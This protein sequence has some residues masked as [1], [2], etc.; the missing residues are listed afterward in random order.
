MSTS[1]NK[2]KILFYEDKI[3][4]NYQKEPPKIIKINWLN[5]KANDKLIALKAQISSNKSYRNTS[6]KKNFR[7]FL[8]SS[9]HSVEIRWKGQYLLSIFRAELITEICE[10]ISKNKQFYIELY[11]LKNFLKLD[12][13]F[14]K[15]YLNT[16]KSFLFYILSIFKRIYL[17]NRIIFLNQ[18]KTYKN[19]YFINKFPDSNTLSITCFKRDWGEIYEIQKITNKSSKFIAIERSRP[20]GEKY[21]ILKHNYFLST[22]EI[23]KSLSFLSI[24]LIKK[25]FKNKKRLENILKI[26]SAILNLPF[27]IK[28]RHIAK[29]LY[30]IN[31]FKTIISFSTWELNWAFFLEAKEKNIKTNIL[32]GPIKDP[33]LHLYRRPGDQIFT[34][35]P[36]IFKKKLT[37]RGRNIGGLLPSYAKKINKSLKNDNKK[38]IAWLE[39]AVFPG[40]NND[41]EIYEGLKYALKIAELSGKPLFVRFKPNIENN[42]QRKKFNSLISEFDVTIVVH[43]NKLDLLDLK[44]HCDSIL[45]SF[46]SG[47]FKLLPYLPIIYLQ[48]EPKYFD[49]DN[50]I[51]LS[52]EYNISSL[53]DIW[54]WKNADE[55]FKIYNLNSSNIQKEILNWRI[56]TLE[57][58]FDWQ[59]NQE[60]IKKS[61]L[62]L[63]D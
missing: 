8:I 7:R 52:K 50:S 56:N 9:I 11:K 53:R 45:W 10:S 5:N 63:I 23:L 25:I 61:W 42:I 16:P 14:K 43:D 20:F 15:R 21:I 58:N 22:K 35:S 62:N 2:F 17:L 30:E 3:E 34:K 54:G 48:N 37:P 44:N 47:F 13:I 27:Y 38:G 51:Y 19:I 24:Y 40:K 46:G 36:H 18:L 26:S 4:I 1:K 33:T 60:E 28:T 31:Q 6:F 12:I 41:L 29:K 59:E 32:I 57:D 39:N 55:A 49:L